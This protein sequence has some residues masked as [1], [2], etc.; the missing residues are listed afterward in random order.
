MSGGLTGEDTYII[1]LDLKA[2]FPNI[3]QDI[4][5]EQLREVIEQDY[6]GRDKDELLYILQSCVFSNPTGHCRQLSSPALRSL[7]PSNKSLFCRP[8]GTGAAIGFLIWQNAVNYYFHEI[9]E[10]LSTIEGI[11]FERFV[12]DIYIITNNKE[13]TLT[14]IPE[15]RRRLS[16]LGAE[17]N[18]RKF[19]C[20][21][22]TKGVECL[23]LHIKKGRIHLNKKTINK[24][25][26]KAKQLPRAVDENIDKALSSLNSYT[27]MIRQTNG[28]KNIM[29]LYSALSE[30]WQKKFLIDKS[31]CFKADTTHRERIIKRYNLL[32]I[33]RYGNKRADCTH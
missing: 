18:E 12:D 20:Q 5:Y 4:A 8:E 11:K 10:W 21:H 14:L 19:Y 22:Y 15:L 23:G 31:L 26:R 29:R 16:L 24:A 30:E 6:E 13:V 32:K 33:N 25:I 1:K 9:D 17:L 3:K 7:I 2:C 27:G 28:Y